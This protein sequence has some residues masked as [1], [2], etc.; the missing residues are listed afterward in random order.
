MTKPKAKALV[1]LRGRAAGYTIT[2]CRILIALIEGTRVNTK[3]WQDFEIE[4]GRCS[5]KVENL[6]FKSLCNQKTV[7]RALEKFV[8]LGHVTIHAGE[9]AR[10][11]NEYTLS[12]KTMQDVPT[13]PRL[14]SSP[15]QQYWRARRRR[16]KEGTWVP[17]INTGLSTKGDA[18]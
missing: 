4:G 13:K 2:E 15:R 10:G 6:A 7:Y 14:I 12:L 3:R 18:Q 11:Q 8:K 16:I 5:T 17:Q 1:L 9:G